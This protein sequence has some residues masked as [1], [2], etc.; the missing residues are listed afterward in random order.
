M[1]AV[2]KHLVW[3]FP[4][5]WLPLVA[6]AQSPVALETRSSRLQ[7]LSQTLRQRDQQ[8]RQDAHA[9]ARA[10][11][12]PLRRELPGGR[13]MEL[14]R[15]VPGSGPVFYL[16]Y[17]IDA[18]DTVSTDEVWPGGSAGLNLDGSGMTV[19]EWDGGAVF[20]EH[21]DFTGRLTQADGASA[22]SGHST[23]VAGTLAGSGAGLFSESRG[24]AHAAQLHAYD[25]NS[26]TAE[27]ASAAAA[28]QLVSNHSY[29]IAAGWL[30]IGDAEPDGWWWI[31]GADPSDVEDA[32]FGY[33]DSESQL[34]DQ[35]A[36]D[37]PYYLIVKAAGNDR[38]DFGAAP[39][40]EYTV[41]DQ[42]GNFLFTSTLP[43]QPDCA[44]AGYD[45]L[46]THSVAKNILTVG[47]VDDLPG[48]YSQLG[49]PGAVSMAD[50]S[51]WGPTDDGRIKP[52]LVGNGILL[53]SAW[54][55]Y[56]YYA[57]A[58]GTSMATPNVTG[59]L[60][61]LQQHYQDLHG[62]GMFLRAAT[63]KA[64]AIHTAD[65]AGADPGPDYAF[66]WGLLNTR[67]AARVITEDGGG[68]H[69]I[70]EGSLAPGAVHTRLINVLQDGA[71]LTAT[72]VWTDPP[73]TPPAPAL[74]PTDLMLV[75]DLDVRI[76]RGATTWQPWVLD[77]ANPAA[78]AIPGDNFR[79]NVEQVEVFG[80]SPGAHLVELRHK[81]SLLDNLPQDYALIIS[82]NPP[83]PTQSEFL[84]DEEFDGGLPAGWSVDTTTGVDWTIRNPVAS[85]PRYDNL[86][87]GSGA[88]AM[89]DNN[90]SS[91]T[92][93]SLR[94]PP[95][96][97]STADAAILRFSSRFSFDTLETINVDASTN[98]GSDW[99]NVWQFQGFNPQPTRYVLDLTG[100]I[101]GQANA[102]LRFRFDSEG[103][104]QGD[105]WQVDDIELE[106]FGSG[107]P[108]GDPPGPAS[109]PTPVHGS[110][111][112]PT[113]SLLSWTGGSG[114]VWHDVYFGTN[115]PP[116]DE[117]Y[118]TSLMT[119]SFDPGPLTANTTYYW[120][121]NEGGEGGFTPGTTW[122]F[123]TG[124][125]QVEV[126]HA[127]GF[128]AGPP[129]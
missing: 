59:S 91:Q 96:D 23:H 48:G 34:W 110:N 30:F 4:V 90:F 80:A 18:A 122:M 57:L 101:G 38:S 42:D 14:Q 47:A 111:G 24:M 5:L 1:N 99:F 25:W 35:I 89:V 104:T 129:P 12:L 58:A 46:P 128:E 107:A 55:E 81:G 103:E 6:M 109:N 84:F 40:E 100:Q 22:V 102:V 63:L 97:L 29:G 67:N 69:W 98:G 44:P 114:A 72:L 10:L 36:F 112:Q 41:I 21:P 16:T 77:P 17:N 106:A 61:L 78:A 15:W 64:L 2:F 108:P 115:N 13:I 105:Y 79:D 66:G 8:Q 83:P 51:G 86:T 11:G 20:A 73:G 87:G 123:T 95:A 85:D 53:F 60:L 70:I 33:Y 76:K 82:A 119:T 121:I 37:A 50:F 74:D 113:D 124:D 43:R 125:G 116:Q 52:D 127:D 28:G 45:C 75:N 68:Q 94:T 19:A 49:G 31:G 54:H 26:D 7:A 9:R 118:R 27:M 126:I 92:V 93:T 117:D 56:P 39:G 71:Q 62:A 65:E 32:N 88:F 120:R 3:L